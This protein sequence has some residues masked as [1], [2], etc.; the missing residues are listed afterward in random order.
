MP[1][2][3]LLRPLDVGRQI[4]GPELSSRSLRTISLDT[5]SA[6]GLRLE[7]RRPLTGSVMYSLLPRED[8]GVRITLS[9]RIS[10]ISFAPGARRSWVRRSRGK[11]T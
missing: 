4:G 11:T 6:L 5:L 3:H 7:T 2:G 9:P 1:V 10:H 8:W